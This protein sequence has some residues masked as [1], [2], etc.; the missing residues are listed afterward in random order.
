MARIIYSICGEGLGHAFRSAE[1]ILELRK[2][3]NVLIIAASSRISDYLKKRF[4]NVETFE[5]IRLSYKENTIDDYTTLRN[6]MKWLLESPKT[7]KKLFNIFR[8][9]KPDLLITDFEGVTAIT[10]N[11]LNIPV[12]CVCN[13]HAMT[14]LKYKT[15]EKYRLIGTKI[16]IVVN[17]IFPKADYH[18]IVSFFKE[19]PKNNNVSLYPPVIRKEFYN[20]KTKKK[21]YILVYQTSDTHSKLISYLKKIDY[22]FI[23]YGF[24]KEGEEGNIVFRKFDYAQMI[25]DLA[26]CNACIAN[27]GF[28]FITEAIFLHKPL[29]CVPIKGQFE[30]ILNSIY[31][32]KLGYGEMY[33]H[34][35]KKKIENFIS[36]LKKYENTLRHVK[37]ENNSRLLHKIEEIIKN[38]SN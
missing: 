9:F 32:K 24:N 35:N 11:M 19:K 18:L 14:K 37:R 10:A 3:H 38:V 17:T 16:K 21:N 1:I 4:K 8:K 12:V 34:I 33:D 27:G 22:D 13:I 15:P 23:I 25:R 28:T 2:K 30:Q 36:N 29:L 5:G 6:Y 26:E 7:I 20:M 31:V